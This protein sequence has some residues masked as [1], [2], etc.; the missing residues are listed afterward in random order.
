MRTARIHKAK[1]YYIE[2]QHKTNTKH[3]T[4]KEATYDP[5]FSQSASAFL[6]SQSVGVPEKKSSYGT[7]CRLWG[8]GQ[9]AQ[10]EQG[11]ELAFETKCWLFF[12]FFLFF[13]FSFFCRLMQERVFKKPLSVCER[14]T[15]KKILWRPYFSK[16]EI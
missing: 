7:I 3:N 1:E 8:V 5:G 6:R 12:S 11:L 2:A 15:I 10:L 13:S 4:H 14:V 16:C 9:L